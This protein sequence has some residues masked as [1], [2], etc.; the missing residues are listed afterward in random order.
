M[1]K[2][3]S[4]R[5]VVLPVIPLTGNS[6]SRK[7]LR[8]IEMVT[9][10]LGMDYLI[11]IE[12]P[13]KNDPCCRK[14]RAVPPIDAA[15]AALLCPARDNGFHQREGQKEQVSHPWV[16]NHDYPVAIGRNCTAWLHVT[17]LGNYAL[18]LV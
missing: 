8:L 15:G 12:I 13:G 17:F 11:L 10:S 2:G 18:S 6:S 9:S 14:S 5:G 16:L 4:R 3:S 7:S 1:G